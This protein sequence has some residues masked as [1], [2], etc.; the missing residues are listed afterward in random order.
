MLQLARVAAGRGGVWVGVR[1]LV[2]TPLSELAGRATKEAHARR[3]RAAD[4]AEAEAVRAGRSL[5]SPGAPLDEVTLTVPLED[6]ADLEAAF[7]FDDVQEIAAPRWAPGEDP[8][9]KVGIKWEDI[10]Y[11][12]KRTL[13][14]GFEGAPPRDSKALLRA[15]LGRVLKGRPLTAKWARELLGSRYDWHSGDL[16]IVAR[17]FPNSAD[18]MRLAAQQLAGV[19]TEA[20]RLAETHG[21]FEQRAPIDHLKHLR[22]RRKRKH[23]PKPVHKRGLPY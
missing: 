5:P 21:D 8:L 9:E 17:R 3:V 16:V 23:N 15:S 2:T 18:N 13:V 12:T 22:Q 1:G 4:A 11:S 20:Q 7:V 19:V 6:L 10:S 14:Q